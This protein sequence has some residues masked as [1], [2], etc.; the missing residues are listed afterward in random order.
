MKPKDTSLLLTLLCISSAYSSVVSAN[1]VVS[2]LGTLDCVVQP[3]ETIDVSASVSGLIDKIYFDRGDNVN[4]GDK[5]IQLDARVQ[6]ADARLASSQA[7]TSTAIELRSAALTLGYKTK[8]RNI[9]LMNNSLIA[10][11]EIDKLDTD[12]R[13]AELNLKL[14]EEKQ[15]LAQIA[16]ERSRSLLNQRSIS[17]PITGVVVERYKSVGERVNDDP[18]L[19]VAQLDPLH[20]EVI[21]PV[22]YLAV[23][24]SGMTASVTPSIAN[25]KNHT[26]T[27]ERIDKVMDAA[28]G[29]FGVRLSLP[30]P[31]YD[32]PAGVLCQLDFAREE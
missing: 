23:V 16:H 19:R 14:E 26:A 3:S 25:A 5:L 20:V 32:I 1:T 24:T 10:A 7:R 15:A 9:E 17:S 29:T 30:N 6:K 4:A 21:V 8:E 28:S 12:I 22:E 11:Q 27:V 13:I 18:I 31:N 2:P